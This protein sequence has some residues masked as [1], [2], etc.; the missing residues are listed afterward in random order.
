MP[1][2]QYHCRR[3]VAEFVPVLGAK[4]CQHFVE[5]MALGLE[6]SCQF[7]S[8]TLPIGDHQ[9]CVGGQSGR[10]VLIA[11]RSRSLRRGRVTA[12]TAPDVAGKPVDELA[13]AGYY[14]AILPVLASALA[15]QIFVSQRLEIP[16]H[17]L[18]LGSD[19]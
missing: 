18:R 14:V 2:N 7:I 16:F 12:D 15:L 17:P 10:Q 6:R 8:E 19:Q 3:M 1:G 5:T 13:T 11:D 9:L 4:T